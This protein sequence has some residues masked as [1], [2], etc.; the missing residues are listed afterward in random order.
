MRV[1]YKSMSI[2]VKVVLNKQVEKKLRQTCIFME[3][4]GIPA[5][6]KSSTFLKYFDTGAR[7]G[8]WCIDH[9]SI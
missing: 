8:A 4:G 5:I 2:K 6:L 7:N 9:F 3:L 1:K